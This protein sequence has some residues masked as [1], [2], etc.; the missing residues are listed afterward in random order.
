M[1]YYECVWYCGSYC[2]CG[3]KKIV[4]KKVLLVVVGLKK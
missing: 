4:L 1:K 3:L 2:G